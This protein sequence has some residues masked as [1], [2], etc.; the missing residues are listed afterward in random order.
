MPPPLQSSSRSNVRCAFERQVRVHAPNCPETWM[1]QAASIA[2]PDV[3]PIVPLLAIAPAA[4]I[5]S[6]A[7]SMSWPA[8]RASDTARPP[9]ARCESLRKP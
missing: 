7:Q 2:L 4:A 1:T 5:S 9:T 3:A 6:V 8:T